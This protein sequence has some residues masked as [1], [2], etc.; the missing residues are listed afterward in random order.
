MEFRRLG[1]AVLKRTVLASTLVG[2]ALPVLANTD[3]EC[4]LQALKNAGDEVTVAELKA[5]CASEPPQAVAVEP[6]SS[7]HTESAITERME[8]TRA[9]EDKPFSILAHQPNYFLLTYNHTPNN[10]P[11]QLALDEVDSDSIDN[12]EIKF[13][14]SLKA[15]LWVSMFDSNASLWV[16]YTN[17]SWWQAFNSFSAPFRET[18]HEPE[19]FV[20]FDTDFS[21]AGFDWRLWRIGLNHES[22]GR[23]AELSRS[24][25]R[26]IGQVAAERGNFYWSTRLWWRI[27]ESEKNDDN[28]DIENYL[29]YGEFYGLYKAGVHNISFML[30]NNLRRDNN[31]GIQVDWSFP[32]GKHLRGQVQYYNGYGESLIDYNAYTNRLGIGLMLT[33]WL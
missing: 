23:G 33:D 31:G 19:V 7:V 13:Q 18:N 14:I 29:G 28:P 2:C 15:P 11:Y 26:V 16:A 17:T 12:E 27:P 9:E 10:D 30:R 25:N 24:W 6:T 20:D 22:N 1:L 21:F 32:L 3:D 5:R 4:L 8:E